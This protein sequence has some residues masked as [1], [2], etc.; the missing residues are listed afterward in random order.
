LEIVNR[1]GSCLKLIEKTWSKLKFGLEEKKWHSGWLGRAAGSP[2][3][4]NQQRRSAG[5]RECYITHK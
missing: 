1:R 3:R 4:K 5:D 2:S